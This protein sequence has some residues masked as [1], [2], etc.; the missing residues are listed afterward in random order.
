MCSAPCITFFTRILRYQNTAV[1]KYLWLL[2][3]KRRKIFFSCFI[4]TPNNIFQKLLSTWETTPKKVLSAKE[5][6]F[7]TKADKVFFRAQGHQWLLMVSSSTLSSPAQTPVLY[8]GRDK[9]SSA[10]STYI[11]IHPQ[12]LTGCLWDSLCIQ[13]IHQNQNLKGGCAGG[14]P[15]LFC[16][17]PFPIAAWAYLDKW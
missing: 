16:R 11:F 14:N 10:N 3:Q 4:S 6:V 13:N 9:I 2:S 17:S 5:D 7:S 1:T 12:M 15:W 8:R